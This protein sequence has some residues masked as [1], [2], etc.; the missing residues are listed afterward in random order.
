MKFENSADFA[1]QA[2]ADD[3]LSRFRN[4]FL[5]PEINGKN[6]LYFTGNSLGLQPRSARE[7]LLNELEDWAKFGVEGHFQARNPWYA[8]HEM[9][10]EPT[11]RLVG[12][13]PNEV[14]VMNGLTTNLHLL[15]VSFFRPQ[16]KRTKILCEA[17][18]F[19]SDRYALDSQLIHHG[20]NPEEHLI[21]LEPRD[22]EHTLRTEDV[23][24]AIEQ[25][26]E[27]LAL[28]MMGG[29]NYYT[30]QFF[31][32]PQITQ[33]AHKVGAIAGWDLAHAAGNVPLQLHDWNVDFA[34]W[35]T[36]KYLNSGPGSVSGVFIHQKHG[37]NPEI[38]RFAGWWGHDKQSRFEMKPGFHPIPGAEGWQLSNAPVFSM[39]VH[40][41]ALDLFDEAGMEALRSKSEQLTAYL[42][43]I[44][45]QVGA[46]STN[47]DFEI[48]TPLEKNARGAQL[49]ILVH[50]QGRPLFEQLME[51]GV[52]VDWREPNV[53]RMAPVPMYNTFSDVFQFGQV[54]RIALQTLKKQ[55]TK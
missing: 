45:R 5:F 7:S 12:A 37:L 25:A 33:A 23:I 38:P 49:S 29:V 13:H 35:C 24:S 20:L 42:E 14:V 30:G 17:K 44:V 11:A 34:A 10:A 52:I 46:D 40:K 9:F 16:D 28:V 53:I 39:A 26:G 15:M 31:D 47:A 55:A 32:I 1:R 54:L 3:T 8:Y 22:G 19:P 2:D 18:A 27:T 41:A 4:Q 51:A 21:A 50:G 48:I 43:F 6:V 36:Y